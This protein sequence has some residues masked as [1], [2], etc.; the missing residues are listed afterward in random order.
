MSERAWYEK[1]VDQSVSS[2]KD[3]FYRDDAPAIIDEYLWVM[4]LKMKTIKDEDDNDILVV[5]VPKNWHKPSSNSRMANCPYPYF[6][7]YVMTLQASKLR[8]ELMKQESEL[9]KYKRY[10]DVTTDEIERIKDQHAGLIESEDGL[11]ESLAENLRV[12]ISLGGLRTNPMNLSGS[13]R[14]QFMSAKK[15]YDRISAILAGNSSKYQQDII[16]SNWYP[17][18]NYMV[19]RVKKKDVPLMEMLLDAKVEHGV[20]SERVSKLSSWLENTEEHKG[21]WKDKIREIEDK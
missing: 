15:E 18:P 2:V 17:T 6:M 5:E 9:A 12:I 21:F 1:L 14:I 20:L 8:M 16:T 10:I 4:D 7:H 3:Y 19:K 11:R 13:R